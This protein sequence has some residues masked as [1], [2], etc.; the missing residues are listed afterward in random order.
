VVTELLEFCSDEF[1]TYVYGP[2]QTQNKVTTSLQVA[3]SLKPQPLKQYMYLFTNAGIRI[4]NIADIPLDAEYLLVSERNQF[5]D[6]TCYDNPIDTNLENQ[7][8]IKHKFQRFQEYVKSME[9]R[10][11]VNRTVGSQDREKYASDFEK[12]VI[13]TSRKTP[14]PTMMNKGPYKANTFF[15]N[16]HFKV[17]QPHLSPIR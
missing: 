5:K 10:N 4:K 16:R 8:S 1:N 17:R 6:I 12:A 14:V 2:L 7:Q 15:L 11:A 9:N 3:S 13:R